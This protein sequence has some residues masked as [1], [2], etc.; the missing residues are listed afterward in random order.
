M[1]GTRGPP[2]AIFHI[3]MPIVAASATHISFVKVSG[4]QTGTPRVG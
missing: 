3:S 4:S 1:S 2:L